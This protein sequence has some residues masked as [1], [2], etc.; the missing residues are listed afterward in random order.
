M[1]NSINK[2]TSKNFE[3]IFS[4]TY[5]N[6][7]QEDLIRV[8]DNNPDLTS[9]GFGNLNPVEFKNFRQQLRNSLR[10]FQSC[11]VYLSLC[12]K[13]KRIY[14]ILSSYGLKSRVEF[15]NGY[16]S[17][18]SFIAAAIHCNFKAH[19]II[20]SPNA[21]FDIDDLVFKGCRELN[22]GTV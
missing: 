14:K 2:F 19:R 4:N 22:L 10:E 7:T 3:E 9:N 11:C 13:S 15:M 16:V 1:K 8:M 20:N 12:K 5:A 6:Y 17:N 21:Y 18:G